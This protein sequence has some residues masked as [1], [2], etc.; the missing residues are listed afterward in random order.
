VGDVG[1]HRRCRERPAPDPHAGVAPTDSGRGCVRSCRALLHIFASRSMA[2][3]HY[4]MPSRT[5]SAPSDMQLESRRL[6]VQHRGVRQQESRQSRPGQRKVELLAALQAV[7]V[8][9]TVS[10]YWI[11]LLWM[12]SPRRPCRWRRRSATPCS[13]TRHGCAAGITRR[14]FAGASPRH[15]ARVCA[16]SSNAV[17][18][19]DFE[20][21]L[22]YRRA[23]RPRR[24]RESR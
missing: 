10:L 2:L 12:N 23:E 18:N 16:D 15:P 1:W 19:F 11:T 3:M 17:G 24:V 6:P 9:A 4:Q 13:A 20:V 5:N 22:S 21:S 14:Q 7:P 8:S